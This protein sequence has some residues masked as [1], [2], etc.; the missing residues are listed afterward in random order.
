MAIDPNL[1]PDGG[2]GWSGGLIG[3]VIVAVVTSLLALRKYLSGESVSLAAN[4]AQT[5]LINLLRTQIENERNRADKA[6]TERDKAETERN[7][8]MTQMSAFKAQIDDLT[9]EVKQLR[10][11]IASTTPL[12]PQ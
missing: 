2:S 3:G 5:E 7:N 12:A 9:Q 6:E 8:A 10:R 1:I 4:A 11:Q